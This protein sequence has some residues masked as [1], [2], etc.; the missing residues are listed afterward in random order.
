MRR[1][2]ADGSH[3]RER[4]HVE[5]RIG[6]THANRELT[7]DSSETA[8]AVRALVA[9]AIESKQPLLTLEDERG[10]TLC[11]PVD[12]LAYVEISGDTGRRMGFA[13]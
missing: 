11:I 7:I 8:D 9:T 3:R 6:V 13:R 2:S 12:K 10:R 5:V 4:T 1:A